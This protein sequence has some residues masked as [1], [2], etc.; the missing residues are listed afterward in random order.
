ML[1]HRKVFAGS[2]AKTES[3]SSYRYWQ[4]DGLIISYY[5]SD[6]ADEPRRRLLQQRNAIE[7]K[8]CSQ[9]EP[10]WWQ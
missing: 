8:L 1:N 2:P 6:L 3:N 4:Y 5:L 7:V 9:Q 10:E